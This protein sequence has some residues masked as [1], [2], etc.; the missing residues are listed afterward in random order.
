MNKTKNPQTRH[1]KDIMKPQEKL[2]LEERVKIGFICFSVLFT[3]Y[4]L[5]V[6]G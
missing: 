3:L 2:S 5:I 4:L 1:N 6:M